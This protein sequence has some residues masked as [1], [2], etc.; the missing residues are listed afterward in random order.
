MVQG[1]HLPS[2]FVVFHDN[3]GGAT[4]PCR[5]RFSEVK[6]GGP[7]VE[8]I[9]MRKLG[10]ENKLFQVRDSGCVNEQMRQQNGDI[11][12]IKGAIVVIRAAGEVVSFISGARL[13][14][15]LEVEFS[16][17]R[18]VTRD[19]AANFLGVAV[20]FQVWMVHKDTN[21]MWRSHQEVA[22]SK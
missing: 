18:K 22:P 19:V 12:I 20:V 10:I 13:I 1:R 21:L 9:R 2:K 7:W 16:H 14:D 8:E 17:F 4:V 5:I 3:Q 11:L 15:K 6:V